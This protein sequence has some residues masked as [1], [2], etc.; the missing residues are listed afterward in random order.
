MYVY[1]YSNSNDQIYVYISIL[2][3]QYLAL[4]IPN[5]TFK[6]LIMFTFL[7]VFRFLN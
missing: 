5:N 6:Y 3:K 7:N 2:Y 4:Q 1:E